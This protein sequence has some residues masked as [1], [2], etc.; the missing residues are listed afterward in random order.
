VAQ[1]VVRPGVF[2][3]LSTKCGFC[4][5][6]KKCGF[7]RQPV[8]RARTISFAT[9]QGI[10]MSSGF[11]DWRKRPPGKS[12]L[13]AGIEDAKIAIDSLIRG[14]TTIRLL[15]SP[16]GLGKDH[17]TRQMC[18]KAKAKLAPVGSLNFQTFHQDLWINRDADVLLMSEMDHMLRTQNFANLVKKWAD[19]ASGGWIT[20]STKAIQKNEQYRLNGSKRYDPTVPPPKFQCKARGVWLSNINYTSP[21]NIP[22]AVKPHWGALKSRGLSP[23][24]IEGTEQETFEYTISLALEQDFLRNMQLKLPVANVVFKIFCEYAERLRDITPR[25]LYM[26]GMEAHILVKEN[27]FT[28]DYFLAQ[29]LSKFAFMRPITYVTRP[30][31]DAGQLLPWVAIVPPRLRGLPNRCLE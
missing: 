15:C 23:K 29:V 12:G 14:A 5:Q 8:L 25:G 4:R 2:A 21:A 16:P 24:W 1:P 19:P 9:I 22:E 31:D 13:L 18:K 11:A 3:P 20:H 26:L 28:P 30:V 7:C 17:L 6:T 27:R 10:S